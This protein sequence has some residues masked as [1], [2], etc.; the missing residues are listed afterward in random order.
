MIRVQGLM[1]AVEDA[2]PEVQ[3][4]GRVFGIW[5]FVFRAEGF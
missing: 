2:R 5:V 1:F 3:G 4:Q